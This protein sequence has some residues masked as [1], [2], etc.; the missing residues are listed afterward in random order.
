MGIWHFGWLKRGRFGLLC[1]N[2]LQPTSRVGLADKGPPELALV[3]GDEQLLIGIL[4]AG[5]IKGPA[6]LSRLCKEIRKVFDIAITQPP[7]A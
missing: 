1:L 6:S 4:G 7:I 5:Q 3:G 2:S